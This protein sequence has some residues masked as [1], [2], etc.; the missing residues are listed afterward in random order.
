MMSASALGLCMGLT[1]A[2]VDNW[3]VAAGMELSG[4]WEGSSAIGCRWV[5]GNA[6]LLITLG[7]RGPGNR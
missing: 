7:A 2:S 6:R 5:C 1:T 3:G 4:K